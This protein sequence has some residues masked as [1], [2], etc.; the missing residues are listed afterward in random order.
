M[1]LRAP[2]RIGLSSSAFFLWAALL[3]F[4]ASPASTSRMA[5]PPRGPSSGWVTAPLQ[6]PR[7]G[8]NPGAR[9]GAGQ[10]DV[11]IPISS[12][13]GAQ[14]KGGPLIVQDS[15]SFTFY[16][17]EPADPAGG[18]TDQSKSSLVTF[19]K[20][21]S[22]ILGQP[23]YVKKDVLPK[24]QT[25]YVNIIGGKKVPK[26]RFYDFFQSILKINDFVLV[27]EGTAETGIFVIAD[28]KS[29]ERLS[30]RNTAKYIP[31]EDIPL[32][33]TQPGVLL[34]TVIPVVN[35]PAREI[36]AS[37]RPYFPDSNLETVTNVGQASALLVYGFGPTVYS[38]Y[39]LIKL[40]D[41]PPDDPKPIFE[42]IPLQNIS[43]EEAAS[44]L[45]DLVEKKK[46]AAPAV[47]AGG[48]VLQG[49]APELKIRV[50][51]HSNSLLV[52]GLQ[53]DVRNVMEIV[54][55]I[56]RAQPEPESDFHVYTVRNIKAEA[57]QK[58]LE[59]FINKSF[60]NRQQSGGAG[61]GGGRTGGGT[62][63]APSSTSRELKPVVV[64]DKDSNSV[65][66][67][68]SKNMWI[69]IRDLIEHLDRRQSQVLIETALIELTTNDAMRLGVELGLVSLPSGD[70]DK[71]FAITNFGAS[72]LI[73]TNNDN[74]ADTRIPDNTLQGLTGGII[75][76]DNFSIPILLQ[77]IRTIS[78]SNVL[79]IPSVLVNN[80]E[81][82]IVSSKDL[83]PTGNQ[84]FSGTNGASN[85]GFGGY[86]DAGITLEITPYI[87]AQNYLRLEFS[88][89]VANF[90]AKTDNNPVIPPPKVER[91]ISTTVYL[92]NESTMVVGGIQFD[93]SNDTKSEVPLLGDIPIIGWLFS[94]RSTSDN[95]RALYFFATPHILSDVEFADLQNLTYQKKLEA[96]TYIGDERLKLVDPAFKPIEPGEDPN[97]AGAINSGLFEIPLYRS[98]RAGEVLPSEVG[99]VP[100]PAPKA[101]PK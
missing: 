20:I 45:D 71:G 10:D 33:A 43:A 69:E 74:F 9:A 5:A 55:R 49:Q 84:T 83:V 96:R 95:R 62:A 52:V 92:P 31:P 65:L 64:A 101:P 79:S 18:A 89:Q 16:F 48:G 34:A 27:L 99:A 13:P 35:T 61:G 54:A 85:V 88:L 86:Q 93:N 30:I 57:L 32:Y 94:S 3:G 59:D 50:D 53:E 17:D 47:G 4:A 36:S 29:T 14:G 98:P 12:V 97:A 63:A 51:G 100:P 41:T 23:F 11:N 72:T 38:V 19:I 39:N 6:N 73:D 87:S 76:G 90:L 66:I 25:T 15:D 22:E 60:Q 58:T 21:G 68:A 91:Q 78:N 26:A 24:L 44:I 46:A 67:T 77:A 80:N 82:A 2:L 28:L 81:H 56:D 7:G 70:A 1:A 75:S 8:Q 37:L 42:I 40:I